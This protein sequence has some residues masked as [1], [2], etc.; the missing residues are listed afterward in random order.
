MTS[1]GIG[2]WMAMKTT[3]AKIND[4]SRVSSPASSSPSLPLP[5]TGTETGPALRIDHVRV[6]RGEQSQGAPPF[7]RRS[8]IN[9]NSGDGV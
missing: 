6:P 7:H 9:Y 4:Q 1:P 3:G 2:A 8:P 5:F